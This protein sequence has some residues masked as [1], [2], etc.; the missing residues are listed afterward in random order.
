MRDRSL[1]W[2]FF[3]LIVSML[4]SA[5]CGGCGCGDDDDDGAG[6]PDDDTLDD[7]A[8][9][10]DAD[11]DDDTAEDDDS[12]DDAGNDDDTDIPPARTFDLNVALEYR[13]TARLIME[14][15]GDRLYGTFVAGEGLGNDYVADGVVLQGHGEVLRFPEANFEIHTLDFTG[16]ANPAS[17][18]GNGP[19]SY[20]LTLTGQ[21]GAA[22][23]Q[24]GL[25]V[26]CEADSTAI[27][28][29]LRLKTLFPPAAP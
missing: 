12:D 18:C 29:I 10:D 11:D 14:Q 2:F 23:R 16:P 26:F 24:G 19:L 25:S 17:G 7:D 27:R 21:V 5:G 13:N 20:A 4:A 15:T 28:R 8:T 9:D 6:T 3:A 22:E 1:P